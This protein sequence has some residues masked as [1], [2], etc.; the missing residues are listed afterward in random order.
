MTTARCMGV[1]FPLILSDESQIPPFLGGE[2]S[3]PVSV[4]G[5]IGQGFR[6]FKAMLLGGVGKEYTQRSRK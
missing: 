5:K 6:G 3:L 4:W 1:L 2:R